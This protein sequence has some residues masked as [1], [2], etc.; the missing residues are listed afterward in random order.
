VQLSSALP[1]GDFSL[2]LFQDGILPA[3]FM[4]RAVRGR[5]VLFQHCTTT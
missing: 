1:Q 4:V 2:S 3:A 5:A